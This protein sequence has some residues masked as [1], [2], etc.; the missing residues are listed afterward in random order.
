M[1][2]LKEEQGPKI[3]IDKNQPQLFFEKSKELQT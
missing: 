2:I 1:T 3:E